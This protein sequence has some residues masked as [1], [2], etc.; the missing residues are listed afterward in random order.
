MKD[1]HLK[2]ETEGEPKLA[3]K[4]NVSLQV[5]EALSKAVIASLTTFHG[6]VAS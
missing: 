5:D 2:F 4:V 3:S 1:G 6:D